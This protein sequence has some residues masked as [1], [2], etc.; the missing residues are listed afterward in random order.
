MLMLYHIALRLSAVVSVHITPRLSGALSVQIASHL[1]GAVSVHIAPHLSNM[2]SV[3]IV[4]RLTDAV[5]CV[6][7]HR[8]R[9]SHELWQNMERKYGSDITH[10]NQ[11]LNHSS[12]NA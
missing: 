10:F 8:W 11:N 7:I 2:V 12:I 4:L 9:H 6:S 5:Q 1:S 3:D